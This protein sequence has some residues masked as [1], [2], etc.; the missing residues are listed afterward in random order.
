LFSFFIFK[1]VS[2]IEEKQKR[3]TSV[4][5]AIGRMQTLPDDFDTALKFCKEIGSID[6]QGLCVKFSF[7][8]LL[9]IFVYTIKHKDTEIY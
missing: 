3:K 6:D 1:A 9:S 5:D 8:L 2:Q 4:Q 7:F